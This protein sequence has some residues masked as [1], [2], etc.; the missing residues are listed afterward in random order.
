M[1]YFAYGSNMNHKQMRKR[2][3]HS[4]FIKRVYLGGYKFVYDGSPE[5]ENAVANIV[6]AEGSIVWGGLFDIDEGDLK[7]INKYEG[8]PYCYTRKTVSV[9]DSEGNTYNAIVFFR[10]GRMEAEPHPEY[11]K[12]VIQGAYDCNL[13]EE[14]IKSTL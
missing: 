10:S 4:R 1:Y 13:P 5:R 8:Y 6:E 11:R 3:P 9:K 14:Y 7:N 2:C 12:I